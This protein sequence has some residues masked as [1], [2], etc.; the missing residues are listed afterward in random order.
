MSETKDKPFSMAPIA[1]NRNLAAE[2]V[3]RL[4]GEILS[5]KL[6]PGSKLPTEQE[7]VAATGVSRTV[8][9]EAVAA[10]RAEGLVVTRQGVG[11]FV[12][13]DIRRRPFRIDEASLDVLKEVINVLELRAAL[14]AEAAAL[15]AERRSPAQL[16]AMREALD[17]MS[18][19]IEEAEDAV[20]PDLDF[21]R[22]IAEATGNPHFTH[23][24]AY[25]GS[26]LIP[27]ARVQSFRSITDD[28]PAYL[29]RVNQEHEDIYAAIQRQDAGAARTAMRM[30]L[31]NSRERL[32][33]AAIDTPG[34][35]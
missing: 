23:L 2:L 7:M 21:H 24:F 14:E 27:R 19:A 33:R 1:A 15:A 17:R 22:T 8:V 25:L 11:A 5:G 29:R 18:L 12:A 32:R 10:L 13:A 35:H 26:L 6:A 16:Q 28:K 34:A 3:E 20:A 4:S 9:R 31:G 30:H